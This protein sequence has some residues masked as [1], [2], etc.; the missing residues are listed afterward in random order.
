MNKKHSAVKSGP[1]DVFLYLLAIAA[2]YTSTVNLITLVFGYINIYLPDALDYGRGLG[3]LRWAIASLIIL[4][5]VYLLCASL[6]NRDI[7]TEPKKI[8]IRIRRW[9][10]YLTLFIAALVIIGDLVTLIY[11]FLEGD[12]TLRFILKVLTVFIVAGSIF[13]YYFF[14]LRGDNSSIR[15]KAAIAASAVVAAVIIVGFFIAGSPFEQRLKKLDERRVSDLQTIQSQLLNYWQSKGSL[16]TSLA[17]LRDDISGFREPVDPE[18]GASYEYNVLGPLSF[19]L[20]ADFKTASGE[21]SSPRPLEPPRG[22]Y[23]DLY[24]ANWEHGIGITC[25]ERVIDP[26]IYRPR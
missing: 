18:T 19:E 22:I 5:P 21:N 4:F 24:A 2:L 16:P 25:F 15:K 10:I 23:N 7:K 26:E 20:C 14:E 3:S 8:E 1:K 17:E 9:L 13:G 11:S 6:I 12:V